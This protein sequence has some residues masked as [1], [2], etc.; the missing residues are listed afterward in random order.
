MLGSKGPPIR[1][2]LGLQGMEWSRD[3]WRHVTIKGQG[4]DPQY[5]IYFEN[6]WRCYFNN[7][8]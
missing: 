3:R 8:R 5:A 1:N 2:G 7:N 4:R 6:S